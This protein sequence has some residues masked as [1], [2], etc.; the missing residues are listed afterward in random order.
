LVDQVADIPGGDKDA[1]CR[2]SEENHNNDQRDEHK[3]LADIRFQD[4][5]QAF[6]LSRFTFCLI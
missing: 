5:Q 4:V 3:V 2:N 6:R 1:V